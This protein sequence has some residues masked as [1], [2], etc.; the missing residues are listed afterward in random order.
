MREKREKE[1]EIENSMTKARRESISVFEVVDRMKE[2]WLL[3]QKP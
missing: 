1:N 2:Q 3:R